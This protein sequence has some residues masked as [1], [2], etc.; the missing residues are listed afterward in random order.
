MKKIAYLLV[1]VLVLSFITI[2]CNED[3]PTASN[4]D[5][6]PPEISEEEPGDNPTDDCCP[7][8]FVRGPGVGDPA[9]ENGDDLVCRNDTP[10]ETIIRDNDVPGQCP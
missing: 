7:E 9:D 2:G 5:T 6:L 3:A 1:S 10:E 8:G 4:G